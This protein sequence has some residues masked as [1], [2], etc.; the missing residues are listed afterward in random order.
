MHFSPYRLQCKTAN[1]YDAPKIIMLNILFKLD[2]TKGY[3]LIIILSH[4]NFI[5]IY[6][7]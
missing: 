2:V 4:S 3:S 5:F 7:R 6:L 1:V